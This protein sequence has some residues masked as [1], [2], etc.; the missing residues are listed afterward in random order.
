[1]AHSYSFAIVRLGTDDARDE[2]L[3]VGLVVFTGDKLDVRVGRRVDKV[4]ALSAGIDIADLRD[5]VGNLAQLDEVLQKGQV[6]EI[7]DRHEQL[8]AVGP[9]S[10]TP[11]CFVVE[12]ASDYEARVSSIL[13]AMVYVEPAPRVVRQV[14]KVARTGKASF[15]TRTRDGKEG[16]RFVIAS[17]L[18]SL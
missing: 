5:L 3:N 1:M 14:I 9:V 18:N 11:A 13:Q 8:R 2:R 12:N 4:R 16:R 17:H 7:S 6:W 10:L 15:Q